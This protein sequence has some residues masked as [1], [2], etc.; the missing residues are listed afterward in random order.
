MLTNGKFFSQHL[1]EKEVEH[2]AE[3]SSKTSQAPTPVV[4]DNL[5]SQVGHV[6]P[7]WD[8]HQ[9]TNPTVSS[10]WDQFANSAYDHNTSAQSQAWM[11]TSQPSHEQ[12]YNWGGYSDQN[13]PPQ[14][15]PSQHSYA[16]VEGYGG[17]DPANYGLM[18]PLDYH[19]VEYSQG[20]T[21]QQQDTNNTQDGLVG[22]FTGLFNESVF[23]R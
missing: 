5:F 11:G 13:Q 3:E 18:Q 22:K 2:G 7:G 19:T 1:K 20:S 6:A 10:S 23:K 15:A 17:A 16:P 9:F 8:P 12:T 21:N 4:Q 14:T